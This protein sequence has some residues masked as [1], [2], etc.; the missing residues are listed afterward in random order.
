MTKQEIIEH[1]QRKG[2]EQI[3]PTPTLIFYWWGQFN[4]ILFGGMLP[5]PDKILDSRPRCKSMGWVVY[6]PNAR[7][8]KLTLG[9]NFPELNT[10]RWFYTV[11]LHEMAHVYTDMEKPHLQHHHG[12]SFMKWK[13][14]VEELGVPFN[15]EYSV[16]DFP[17]WR[18]VEGEI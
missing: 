16:I 12:K 11:L 4:R 15:R 9:L 5:Y 3:V 17:D 1:I 14:A 10:R 18:D 8:Y 6:N 13:D 2:R 7:K